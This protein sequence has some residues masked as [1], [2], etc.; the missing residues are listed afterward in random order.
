MSPHIHTH[1]A[2]LIEPAPGTHY[3]HLA[4]HGDPADAPE[5]ASVHIVGVAYGPATNHG[6]RYAAYTIGNPTPRKY[7]AD[8]HIDAPDPCDPTSPSYW[9][10]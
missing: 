10:L 4:M 5:D 2:P 8:M 9:S 3:P 6:R 7:H 1:T